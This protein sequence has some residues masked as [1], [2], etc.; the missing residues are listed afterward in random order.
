MIGELAMES[1]VKMSGISKA[2][3]NV[4]ANRDV[5]FE[6]KKG[7]IHALLGEN[8]AGK[9]TLM[10]ILYGMLQP[11]EGTLYVNGKQVRI[12]NPNKAIKLGIGMIH[13]H[14]MLNPNFT[15]AENI[16]TGLK[17][18]NPFYLNME[19]I[20]QDIVKLSTSYGLPVD[21]QAK[22]RDLSVGQQQR[23][24]IVK[25]LYRGCDVL[26]M[27]EPTAVLLPQ[28]VDELFEILKT[29][30]KNG[31]SVILISHKL[32]ELMKIT[33]RI[34][35]M[36]NGEVVGTVNTCDVDRN[37]LARLMVGRDI[38]LQY[39]KEVAPTNQVALEVK[40]LSY[41]GKYGI[42]A[43]DDISMQIHAGEIVGIAGV[44]GN[45]QSELAEAIAGTLGH[46]DGKVLLYGKDISSLSPRERYLQ[47]LAYVPENRHTT[48][49]I[50]KL[51]IK[52]NLI[53]KSYRYA[54]F[55]SRLRLNHKQIDQNASEL[56][57][58]YKIKIGTISDPVS[59]FLEETN[60]KSSWPGNLRRP[61]KCL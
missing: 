3:G 48:G 40:N 5:N 7:E 61:R 47:K 20:K 28:E 18:N 53:L 14:F 9:T 22:V 4:K 31:A 13:R 41:T 51:S 59:S 45:G 23:I 2:F 6:L 10:K 24:E 56:V 29:F 37:Q 35:I 44:D 58:D 38:S 60:K 46:V 33:D 42:K 8:G 36:R 50:L 52:L 54:P 12:D 1:R 25:A 30:V 43:L 26:I 15:V 32:Q 19:R 39:E 11:D 49:L 17:G 16:V 34:T 57:Q 55:F 21:P 27:D